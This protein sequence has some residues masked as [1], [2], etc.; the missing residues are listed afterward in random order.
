MKEIL[1][2]YCYILIMK[3]QKQNI[4]TAIMDVK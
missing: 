4:D 2:H 3:L 1:I